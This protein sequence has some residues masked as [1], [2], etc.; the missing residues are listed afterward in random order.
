[1]DVT[2]ITTLITTVGFP[3]VA[4]IYMAKYMTSESEAHAKEMNG[5][6]DALNANTVALQELKQLIS[7]LK[8]GD[9]A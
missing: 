7:D 3:I 1:M 5:M 9:K 6:K 4:C 2:Q 8:G